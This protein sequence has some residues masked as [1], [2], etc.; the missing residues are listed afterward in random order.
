MKLL[1][2]AKMLAR[3]YHDLTGKPLGVTGEIAEYEAARL[4]ELELMPA[5]QEGFDAIDSQGRH[6]QIKG[7]R[8]LNRKREDSQRVGSIDMR[9]KD[10]EGTEK[11]DAVL[12]VLLDENFEAI[13]IYEAEYNKVKAALKEE[14]SKARNER[15]SLSVHKFKDI[16]KLQWPTKDKQLSPTS[17]TK[18]KNVECKLD[19]SQPSQ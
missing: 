2:M 18:D 14:G 12:L 7:R 11:I 15:G 6:L 16:G 1:E 19:S 8:I 3:W 17:L 13:A 4:L 10:V 5:R 9:E